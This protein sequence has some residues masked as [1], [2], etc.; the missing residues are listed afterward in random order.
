MRAYY[1]R[2][3]ISDICPTNHKVYL[4]VT[5]KESVGTSDRI[6][7]KNAKA[8]RITEWP[9]L[10][11][12]RNFLKI[13]QSCPLHLSGHGCESSNIL[14]SPKDPGPCSLPDAGGL[15]NKKLAESICG[16]II[17]SKIY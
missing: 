1:W 4:Q 16:T 10:N 3:H 13:H 9:M 7:E 11:R 15:I 6:F 2:I 12:L 14:P 17:R 8:I 5:T